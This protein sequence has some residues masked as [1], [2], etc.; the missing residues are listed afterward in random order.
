M[1]KKADQKKVKRG[2][3]KITPEEGTKNEKNAENVEK[4][5]I[6]S[7]KKTIKKKQKENKKNKEIKKKFGN[8]KNNFE[9]DPAVLNDDEEN[10]TNIQADIK[11]KYSEAISEV[12][13]KLIPLL[14]KNQI[15]LA[16]DVVKNIITAKYKNTLNILADEQEEFLYLNFVF[17][18][19]PVK[20][21]IRPVKINL[22]NSIYGEKFNTNV[23]LIVKDPK[24]DFKNLEIKVPFNLKVLDI[25]SLKLKYSRF[26]QRRNLL[27]SYE[28]FLCDYKVYMILKKLLGKSFYTSKKFPIPIKIDYSNSELTKAEILSQIDN[29]S[30]FYMSHG[31]NYTIKVSRSVFEGSETYKN[32]VD[33]IRDTIPHISKW[34]VELKE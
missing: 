5:G 34:G 23:C 8:D 24:S 6:L 32:V 4:L 17:G 28:I 2:D 13:S 1:G 14:N 22:S 3:K 21:S 27:K 29:C 19:L 25:Q 11:L 18:K 20:Y 12:N 15:K 10:N 33:G 31:P 30:H 26:E 16:I 7:K 9:D